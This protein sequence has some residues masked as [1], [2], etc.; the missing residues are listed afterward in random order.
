MQI[1]PP[2]KKKKFH[3]TYIYHAVLYFCHYIYL[4]VLCSDFH[5]QKLAEMAEVV[6][7]R[8][9]KL[10]QYSQENVDLVETNNILRK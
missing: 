6:D 9:K 7:A 4:L 1:C 8:E 2:P 5:Q 10:L 3:N